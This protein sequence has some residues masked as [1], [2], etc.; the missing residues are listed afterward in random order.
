MQ[1]PGA[2][3]A[4]HPGNPVGHLIQQ[5]TQPTYSA[6]NPGTPLVQSFQHLTQPTFIAPD[7]VKQQLEQRFGTQAVNQFYQNLERNQVGPGGQQG[8]GS[9][10]QQQGQAR[11]APLAQ[12]QVAQALQR[13]N[14]Q[15][16]APQQQGYQHGEQNMAGLGAQAAQ[17]VHSGGFP[18]QQDHNHSAQR[19]Q[20]QQADQYGYQVYPQQASRSMP[21]Q[22]PWAHGNN[23][24]R[25]N[26]S[27]GNAM[28]PR[29]DAGGSTQTT[30]V[31]V[32]PDTSVLGAGA[33]ADEMRLALDLS[34]MNYQQ[35]NGAANNASQPEHFRFGNAAENTRG[36]FLQKSTLMSQFPKFASLQGPIFRPSP[37][38]TWAPLGRLETEEEGLTIRRRLEYK[39][40]T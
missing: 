19:S 26:A 5:A 16:P 39:G 20:Y 24:H 18:G 10:G 11:N 14:Y 9:H 13:W 31:Q 17:T 34:L 3:S 29:G 23:Q 36:Q 38:P 22:E 30:Q 7:P 21:Q 32:Q 12:E 6:P 8:Y 27:G 1:Q 15:Y 28:A 25:N 37:V 35:A 33:W 4:P 40:P 2:Y